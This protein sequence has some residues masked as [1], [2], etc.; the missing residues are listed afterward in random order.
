MNKLK[1]MALALLLPCLLLQT[2]AAKGAN[3]EQR[4]SKL[5]TAG[6]VVGGLAVLGY[7]GFYCFHRSRQKQVS[8]VN[9][10]IVKMYQPE[11]NAIAQNE[12]NEEKL[13]EIIEKRH[14]DQDYPLHHYIGSLNCHKDIVDRSLLRYNWKPSDGKRFQ[15]LSNKLAII[16]FLIQKKYLANLSYQKKKIG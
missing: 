16:Q 11:R 12:F 2:Q 4:G 1:K 7:A 5:L 3:Q 8:T 13:C 10:D 9:N 6:K 15:N 14:N